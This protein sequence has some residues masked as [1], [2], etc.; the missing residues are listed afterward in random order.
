MKNSDVTYT[1][2]HFFL[3]IVWRGGKSLC[4]THPFWSVHVLHKTSVAF[5]VWWLTFSQIHLWSP[6]KFINSLRYLLRTKHVT[7]PLKAA[8]DLVGICVRH[9]SKF[10]Y[11]SYYHTS[12]KNH[13]RPLQKYFSELFFWGTFSLFLTNECTSGIW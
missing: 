4:A 10:G 2:T 6:S 11:I 3:I 8:A 13:R 7:S 12:F 1:L 9:I 5:L